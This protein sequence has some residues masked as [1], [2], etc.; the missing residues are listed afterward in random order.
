MHSVRLHIY[1][2]KKNKHQ[3]V[4][5]GSILA[6]HPT[7]PGVQFMAFAIFSSE[8]ILMLPRLI[9]STAVVRKVNN[10]TD[11]KVQTKPLLESSAPASFP[12]LSLT[13]IVGFGPAKVLAGGGEH[14]TVVSILAL[15]PSS[16][17][18]ISWLWRFLS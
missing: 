16:P 15:R 3:G 4:K 5:E 10:S 1:H 14:S 11:L 17:E 2:L 7:V 18:F 13:C 6:F 12:Y 8:E 9:D